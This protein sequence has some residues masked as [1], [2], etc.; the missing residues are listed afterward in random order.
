MNTPRKMAYTMVIGL[1]LSS[2]VSASYALGTAEQRAACTPDVFRLCASEIP[3]VD[4]IVACMKAKKPSLS[5]AC[6]AVFNAPANRVMPE[7]TASGK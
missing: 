3:N 4:N 7:K 5:P 6:R 1:T 2:Y